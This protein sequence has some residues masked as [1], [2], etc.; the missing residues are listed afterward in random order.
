MNPF[1]RRVLRVCW[2]LIWLSPIMGFMLGKAV[3][4]Q[5][6]E[7]NASQQ[8]AFKVDHE[9]SPG[10]Y[11][12]EPKEVRIGYTIEPVED[13]HPAPLLVDSL[14]IC[15]TYNIGPKYFLHCGMDRY[16]IVTLGLIPKKEK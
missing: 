12:V 3:A 14:V 6:A 2:I 4:A 13:A 9:K 15:R 11:V 8:F 5:E 7:T 1:D 10:V 16:K